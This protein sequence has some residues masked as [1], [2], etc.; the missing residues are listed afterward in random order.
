MAKIKLGTTLAGSLWLAS[1]QHHFGNDSRLARG[2]TYFNKGLVKSFQIV[3]YD[4]WAKVKGSY[5]TYEV[6]FAFSQFDELRQKIIGYFQA[7]PM[8]KLG[9]LQGVLS[10]EFFDW[11]EKEGINWTPRLFRTALF[12]HYGYNFTCHCECYDFYDEDPCKHIYALMYALVGEIDNNPL[13]LLKLHGIE[14]GDIVDS[15]EVSQEIVYPVEIVYKE[16]FAPDKKMLLEPIKIVHHEESAGFIT[17]LLPKNPPFAPI[18]YQKAMGEFYKAS[19]QNLPQL[20]SL[21]SSEHGEKIERLFKEAKIEIVVDSTMQNSKAILK[22]KVFRQEAVIHEI[23]APYMIDSNSL[24]CSI[25]LLSFVRLF[26]SFKSEEGSFY[27]RYFYQL[28]RLGYLIVHTSSFIP[29]VIKEKAK[30]RFFIGWIPLETKTFHEQLEYTLPHAIASVRHNQRG[31]YFD[32]LSGTKMFLGGFLSEYVRTLGFMH[33]Q[34]H[35]NPPEI[36]KT[37]FQGVP[38][39][40]KGAG[41]HNID[42][43]VAN[44]F[45]IFM[46]KQ[47]NYLLSLALRRNEGAQKYELSL[48]AKDIRT[49]EEGTFR[50]VLQKDVAKELLKLLAPMRGVLPQIEHFFESDSILLEKEAFEDFILERASLLQALGV[51][52]VLP[53]ELHNLIKPRLSLFAKTKKVPQSFLEL[54]KILEYDWKIA[55][56]EHCIDIEEFAALV[57]EQG[58]IVHYKDTCITLTPE[59]FKNLLAGAKKKLKATPFDVLRERFA[60]NLQSDASLNIF[61]EKL[62]E[63]KIIHMPKGLQAT[64]REY[65][66][67]GIAWALSNLLNNFGV[68]LADDMGLGKTIQTIA[69]L[70]YLYENQHAKD[71]TL[72]VVPTSLLN[73]WQNELCKF[74]PSLS[75][76]LYYGQGRKLEDTRLILTTYDTLKRDEALSGKTFDAVVIDE[77]QKIKNPDTQAAVAVKSI[78]SKYK[79]AL[80]GTPVENSLS[81]LWS[82]FDFALSGYLGDLN[83]FIAQY[84]KP[85]EIEKDAATAEMLK[86]IT[87]PFM[88]RRLKTDKSIIDD[89]PDKIV[90]DEY[91]SMV[92]KQAALYQS[93]VDTTM[94]KLD[95]LEPSERFGLV[96]KLITELKQ[97]CNHPRNFDKT[98]EIDALISG[99]TQMLME[100]LEGILSRGEKVLIFTQYVAMA[101][102]LSEI[103][104]KA[105]LIE[106]LVLDGSLSKNARQ[107]LVDT[108]EESSQHPVFILSLKAGGVGL[109]LTSASNVIHYDLWFNPAVE[110]Q[111]TDRAFRIGQTKN[112]FVYRLITKNS[113]EEKIDNM[114]KAKTAIGE[115]SVS[116]GEKSIAS[117]DNEEIKMLF[118]QK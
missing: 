97:V 16:S 56:G 9:L 5:G 3:D 42:K 102:I 54:A 48:H 92:P 14:I 94:Q 1:L 2:K 72:I 59:E 111:A 41:K 22:H 100:L 64:L 104:E 20:V 105:M 24:G 44:T 28:C 107:K 50:E 76:S 45:S 51:V 6:D 27:Y 66:R 80:S 33:K 113:F 114:I 68:I 49:N 82:I 30:S 15:N 4:V 84:A 61:F 88:L 12:R 90:I 11:C 46:L 58:R 60:G 95:T 32:P 98:S 69:V 75:Y 65:Q 85:I 26:L 70:L 19:K 83:S 39:A 78:K 117:M 34:R 93:I 10:Q 13:I 81:E 38:F 89:L 52:L 71:A 35:A 36:S 106:P 74:A 31:A 109:N 63:P 62:F 57:Q 103:I 73:N 67:R 91:V 118:S 108:F 55:I 116:V 7:N 101:K 23:L 112:V 25:D 99:K 79:I 53:K 17:S 47:G 29:A 87:A 43:A 40:Q 110:N 18:D 96:F 8:E 21:P 86:K 37:F 77:A 115:M